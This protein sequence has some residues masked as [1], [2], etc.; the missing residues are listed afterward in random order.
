MSSIFKAA[1][2]IFIRSSFCN[3]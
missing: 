1:I 2:F 3:F